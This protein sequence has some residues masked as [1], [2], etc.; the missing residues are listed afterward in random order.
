MNREEILEKLNSIF[1]DAFDDEELTVSENT[2]AKDVDGWDSLM[3]I[4]LVF[5]I[6]SEWHIHFTVE[7]L[8]KLKNV[9]DMITM[10]QKK[11]E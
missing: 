9:G 5:S 3:Q 4:T 8:D 7:D 2:A 10:I 1:Q 11:M 6:E